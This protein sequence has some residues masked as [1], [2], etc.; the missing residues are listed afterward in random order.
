MRTYEHRT[1]KVILSNKSLHFNGRHILF[2]D[3]KL[4]LDFLDNNCIYRF[5]TLRFSIDKGSIYVVMYPWGFKEIINNR[6]H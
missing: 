6:G 1:G 3:K 5:F 4:D 2:G